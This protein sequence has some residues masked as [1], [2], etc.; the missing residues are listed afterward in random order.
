MENLGCYKKERVL[1]TAEKTKITSTEDLNIYEHDVTTN[2]VTFA[3]KFT[4]VQ[5]GR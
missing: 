1:K 2:T 5:L 3:G 4:S